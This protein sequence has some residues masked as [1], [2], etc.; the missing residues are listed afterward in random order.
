VSAFR[1][2]LHEAGFVEGQNV[3]IEFTQLAALRPVAATMIL[4]VRG[5]LRKASLL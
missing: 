4:A 3:A 2:G 5:V 1:Q